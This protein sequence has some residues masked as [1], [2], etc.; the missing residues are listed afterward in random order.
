MT[1]LFNR[2]L[3]VTLYSA[4]KRHKRTSLKST[5]ASKTEIITI[6]EC[7]ELISTK[8]EKKD[9]EEKKNE[10]MKEESRSKED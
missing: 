2:N 10:V 5:V 7:K 8:V 3:K 6:N 4:L 9:E 1:S